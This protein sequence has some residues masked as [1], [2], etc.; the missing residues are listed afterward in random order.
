MEVAAGF[1]VGFDNDPVNIFQR[2]IDFIQ[3]SGI[4]TAM[5]GLLN[6]PRLSRLYKRLMNEGRILG[7]FTGDNT[8]FSMNFL[9][10][11]DRKVFT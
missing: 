10:V 5:V 8:D 3:Q 2:Q 4:I 11:M 7:K 9:P 1:I 6:A